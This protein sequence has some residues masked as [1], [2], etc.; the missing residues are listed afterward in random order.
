MFKCRRCRT[1]W[2]VKN[3]SAQ[4]NHCP[5]CDVVDYETVAELL[6]TTTKGVGVGETLPTSHQGVGVGPHTDRLAQ[7]ITQLYIAVDRSTVGP[8]QH[9][10][11]H[12]SPLAKE[13]F[14]TLLR[15]DILA[16]L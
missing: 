2:A 12:Y 6:P 8:M 3:P 10:A 9:L 13:V 16:N 14:L 4:V 15:G 7:K 1:E 5:A 11:G